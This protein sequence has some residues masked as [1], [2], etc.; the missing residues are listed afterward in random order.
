MKGKTINK[1]KRILGGVIVTIIAAVMPAKIM[2]ADNDNL[3]YTY[4][5]VQTLAGGVTYEKST[6]LY[7]SGWLDVYVLTM[8]MNN[9]NVSFEVI[10][11]KNSFGAKETVNR[12]AASNNVVAAVNGDFFGAGNPRSSMGQVFRGGQAEQ[13]QNYYNSSEKKYAGIFVDNENKAF[14]DYVVSTVGFYN[15]AESIIELQAKNK[16]TDFAKPVY[17]DRNAITTT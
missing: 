17:F 10:E 14:I 9:P 11:S 15:S 13:A 6:R 5:D 16:V 3:L 2:L 12:L 7:K 4:R 1:I 8:D